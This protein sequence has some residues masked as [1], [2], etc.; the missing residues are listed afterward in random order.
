MVGGAVQEPSRIVFVGN[1]PCQELD[2][3]FGV[4]AKPLYREFVEHGLD[5]GSEAIL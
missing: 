4:S 2:G 1:P 3:G 5:Y